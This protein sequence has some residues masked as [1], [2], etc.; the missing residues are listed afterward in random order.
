[1]GE[2]LASVHVNRRVWLAVP[3]KDRERVK[4]LGGRWDGRRRRWYARN[5]GPEI[6]QWAANSEPPETTGGQPGP[7]E[8]RPADRRPLPPPPPYRFPFN[9][10]PPPDVCI[11]CARNSDIEHLHFPPCERPFPSPPSLYRLRVPLGDVAE[12]MALGAQ[13]DHVGF[14]APEPINPELRRWALFGTADIQP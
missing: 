5:P 13:R 11:G 2:S 10:A 8:Q 9:G 7:Q 3:Y 14:Y 12:V 1:M 4:E 6:M